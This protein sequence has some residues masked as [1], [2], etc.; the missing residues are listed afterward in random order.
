MSYT[1]KSK[2]THATAWKLMMYPATLVAAADGDF[3]CLE[4]ANLASALKEAASG[5][6]F[7]KCEMYHL[8]CNLML[9]NEEEET[10]ILTTI[11]EEI[12]TRDELK[13][14]IMQ[15]GSEAFRNTINFIEEYTTKQHELRIT[16]VNGHF[17]T[18]KIESQKMSD[19]TGAVDWRQG[20][21]YAISFIPTETPEELKQ[22]CLEFLKYF[23]LN[24]G[25]FDFILTPDNK[26]VF[27]ECN[28]N[29][30]WLWLED[31]G[32]AISPTLAEVFI[33]RISR[34]KN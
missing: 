19:E 31:A 2:E 27:L 12:A 26:Y 22:P 20:Y 1:Q 32:L 9:V 11:K 25:C 16:V 6:D 15:L 33:E 28:T 10:E 23:D 5:D 7:K 18:A 24:F 4:R 13:E 34:K 30:Q 29:G 21:D 8:L 17:F 3:S 14:I